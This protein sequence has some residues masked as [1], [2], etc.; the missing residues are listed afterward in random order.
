M[1][2]ISSPTTG[3]PANDNDSHDKSPHAVLLPVL[4]TNP[5]K[6]K[7]ISLA[8]LQ[9]HGAHQ[10]S[11]GQINASL[12]EF[13]VTLL[14]GRLV[15]KRFRAFLGRPASWRLRDRPFKSLPSIFADP[16][17]LMKS[18]RHCCCCPQGAHGAL[19]DQPNAPRQHPGPSIS[20]TMDAANISFQNDRLAS[21]A[22]SGR[23]ADKY[24]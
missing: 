5:V 10:V 21:P 4:S 6:G 11:G 8:Q 7:S 13:P 17:M 24:L 1:L 23:L 16:P 22:K 14:L 12:L 18:A 2:G 19:M 20:K 9:A 3:F 15:G